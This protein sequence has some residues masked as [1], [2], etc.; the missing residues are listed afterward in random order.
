MAL[1][2]LPCFLSAWQR[3][4]AL[5]VG[6]GSQGLPAPPWNRCPFFLVVF[7]PG[8]ALCSREG[9][10]GGQFPT[11]PQRTSNRS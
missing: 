8:Q 3:A 6:V 5:S 1:G 11:S 4:W 9:G 2:P 7:L 10:V